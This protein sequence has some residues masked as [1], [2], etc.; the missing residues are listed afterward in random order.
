MAKAQKPFDKI[1]TARAKI[2]AYARYGSIALG[3]QPIDEFMAEVSEAFGYL[4]S[5][6]NIIN[7]MASFNET[8]EQTALQFI[9]VES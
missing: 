5:F 2:D 7:A 1:L 9:D 3:E 4:M 6:R 8:P